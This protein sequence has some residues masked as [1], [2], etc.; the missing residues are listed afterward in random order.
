MRRSSLRLAV[1]GS[2]SLILICSPSA[3]TLPSLKSRQACDTLFCPNLDDSLGAILNWVFQ[4]SLGQQ[5]LPL[6]PVENHDQQR[7]DPTMNTDSH[8]DVE[9]FITAQPHGPESCQ[10]TPAP[11]PALQGKEG[12]VGANM[13][14]CEEATEKIIWPVSCDDRA[15]NEITERMLGEI[16]NQYWAS[17][18]PLCPSQGGIAFWVARLTPNQVLAIRG[19]KG[20]AVRDITPNTPFSIDDLRRVPAAPI[21]APVKAKAHHF[22]KRASLHVKKQLAADLSLTFLS[23]PVEKTNENRGYAYLSSSTGKPETR[24]TIRI[25]VIDSGYDW[26]NSD[27]QQHASVRWLYAGGVRKEESDIDPNGH[28]TCIFTKIGGRRYGVFKEAE[29]VMVK[30]KVK[31]ASFLSALSKII[32]DRQRDIDMGNDMRGHVVINISG[33]WIQPDGVPLSQILMDYMQDL[34][35]S[36]HAVVVTSAGRDEENSWGEI[37]HMPAGL[38]ASYGIITVGAVNPEPG[39]TYGARY[40]WSP[41]GDAL[42]VTGPGRGMCQIPNDKGFQMEGPSMAGAVVSGLVAYFLS[43]PDLQAHFRAQA[44]LPLA[45]KEFLQST[46]SIRRYQAQKS[47]WNGLDFDDN[48]LSYDSSF[49]PWQYIPTLEVP[50]QPRSDFP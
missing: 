37:V 13:Q 3:S 5:T 15:A 30:S 1:F 39:P 36:K 12:N 4:Q 40:A 49:N 35:V 46:M 7:P 44:N 2:A 6:P 25:Y 16:D 22:K 14:S 47:V 9:I 20:T 24:K 18:N 28:G 8:P 27:F 45:V 23:T 29:M 19:T 17:T 43:I 38:G 48:T 31:E 26:L 21:N 10:P 11:A 34:V 41:G 42:T 33:G 32:L 50:G